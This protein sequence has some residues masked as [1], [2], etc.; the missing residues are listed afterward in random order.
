MEGAFFV[1]GGSWC[2]V[3]GL[4][5]RAYGFSAAGFAVRTAVSGGPVV[6]LGR[7]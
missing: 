3:G 7:R 2:G 5:T 4:E 6:S 1:A